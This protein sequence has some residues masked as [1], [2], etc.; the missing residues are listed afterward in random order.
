MPPNGYA[1][2]DTETTGL[3][4]T[5][6]DRIIELGIVHL[7][8]SGEITREWGS[9][10]NPGRDLGPQ[11]IHRIIAA[12]VRHAPAFAEVAGTVADLLRGRV[13]VAHNLRFDLMFL[14]EEFR[15]AGADVPL[16]PE[17]GV[18][19]M[20]WAPHFLPGA[21]RNLAGCCALAEVS[22]DGH[23]DALVDARAA[24]GLLRHYIA[25]ARARVPWQDLLD[26][27]RR[28]AQWPDLADA[29][30]AEV[31]RG[32]SAERDAHFLARILDRMPRVAEPAG[33]DSY[34]ALLDQVL[35]D[36]HISPT[37]ADA[38]IRFAEA[39]GLGRSDLERLHADY[40]EALVRAARA[41]GAVT[42]SRREELA[43]VAGLL[44]LPDGAAERALARTD[45]Q[46]AR[47]FTMFQLNNGDLVAFT[48]EMGAGRESLEE[49]ARTAGYV[50]HPRVT[51][52][53][54][55]LV[56]ADPDTLSGKARK[57]RI[58]GIP[59]VTAQAFLRLI[60]Q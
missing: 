38:L 5:W 19:T 56:A 2:I 55:L 16:A 39:V 59:I 35:L 53:V 12:D 15:R 6:H 23:H 47:S 27:S 33:A 31:R 46:K 52:K 48:G 7:D 57:A 30:L 49:R 24:A 51:R 44:G 26:A 21:P 40:L 11:R 18:C 50:P 4:P 41:E 20:A 32:V 10:V 36:H 28:P 3:R 8:A 54:K 22:L 13:V 43:S 25:L 1:V 17:S 45:G 9:L 34:L 60:G 14:A 42:R 29:G 58:Y 37:E